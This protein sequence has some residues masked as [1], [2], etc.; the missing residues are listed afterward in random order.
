[1]KENID[2]INL[3]KEENNYYRDELVN[4]VKNIK[5]NLKE[6]KKKI[7]VFYNN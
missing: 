1:M 7:I 2:I 6:K 4:Y 3:N 5:N